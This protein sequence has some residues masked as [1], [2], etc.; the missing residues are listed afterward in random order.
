MKLSELVESNMKRYNFGSNI[1]EIKKKISKYK[2]ISKDFDSLSPDVQDAL[3]SIYHWAEL[4]AGDLDDKKKV[5]TTI[6]TFYKR[7]DHRNQ[8][9]IHIMKQL[10][11]NFRTL[12]IDYP[13]FKTIEKS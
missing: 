12:G 3:V 9:D 1:A 10:I 7:L 2:E 5:L 13:E 4:S 6:L 11:G 8:A